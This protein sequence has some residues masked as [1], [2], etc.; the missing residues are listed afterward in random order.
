[1]SNT[2]RSSKKVR[3]VCQTLQDKA[4]Q[5]GLILDKMQD[6]ENDILEVLG[7]IS[8]AQASKRE[9]HK[10]LDLVKSQL[11]STPYNKLATLDSVFTKN[12]KNKTNEIQALAEVKFAS[13]SAG[14]IAPAHLTPENVAK[15]YMEVGAKAISVLCEEIGFGG[16]LAYLS[17]IRKSMPQACLLQKD[18]LLNKYQVYEGR[19]AGAST[20]LI[21][22]SLVSKDQL[23]ELLTTAR[24]LNI[25]PLIE[26]HNNQELDLVIEYQKTYPDVIKVVGVNNRD[27]TTF[28][29]DLGISKNIN[30]SKL[31]DLQIIT[32]S[33]SGIQSTSEAKELQASGYDAFLVG[34]TFMKT[35]DPKTELEYF[36]KGKK[37]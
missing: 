37:Q 27:L 12:I 21:I 29:V 17:E 9:E 30:I 8:K 14:R 4:Q 7:A 24:E 11:E 20:F 28:K 35:P 23:V 3:A 26:I 19:L 32:L 15:G 1:M 22:I 6:P 2:Q 10:P 18:F 16:S 13:P 34:T 36:I 25:V 33:E 31:N 5:A